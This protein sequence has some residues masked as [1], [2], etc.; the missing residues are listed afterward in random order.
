M[1]VAVDKNGNRA[2]TEA[3]NVLALNPN[4]TTVT[5]YADADGMLRYN[6]EMQN[7]FSVTLPAGSKWDDE[8]VQAIIN[9]IVVLPYESSVD[10]KI[11]M[12]T[13]WK[14]SDGI[15]AIPERGVVISDCS[16]YASY[17]IDTTSFQSGA[18][19]DG[20]VYDGIGAVSDYSIAF[21]N[22]D[23]GAFDYVIIDLGKEYHSLTEF[24]M[25][26]YADGA[27]AL[28]TRITFEVSSKVYVPTMSGDIIFDDWKTVVEYTSNDFIENNGRYLLNGT[29]ANA[30]GRY[31][32]ISFFYDNADSGLLI[33]EIMVIGTENE[34]SAEFDY[35]MLWSDDYL[36][37]ALQYESNEIPF[38]VADNNEGKDASSFRLFMS[39][40]NLNDVARYDY[41]NYD[42]VLDI[43]VNGDGS[44][45]FQS[46]SLGS[47]NTENLTGQASFDGTLMTVELAIPF[48][49]LGF[50]GGNNGN[51]YVQQGIN[52]PL[53]KRTLMQ[54]D[55]GQIFYADPTEFGYLIQ[56]APE[57][58][59]YQDMSY[60]N[61]EGNATISSARNEV[62]NTQNGV[63]IEY[64]PATFDVDGFK[65][66]EAN[67]MY[68]FASKASEENG[69]AS[70]VLTVPN[71]GAYFSFDW[72]MSGADAD[73]LSVS[74]N[75]V[76]IAE[77]HGNGWSFNET[78]TIKVYSPLNTNGYNDVSDWNNVT[79]FIPSSGTY[80]VK[81]LFAKAVESTGEAQITNFRLATED[82]LGY[83]KSSANWD[84]LRLD[85]NTVD[86]SELILGV[87][88]IVDNLGDV[89]S[90]TSHD[91][92]GT[93]SF[94]TLSY[95]AIIDGA[96]ETQDRISISA[97]NIDMA[98]IENYKNNAIVYTNAF[99]G[100]IA[101]ASLLDWTVLQLNY[102]GIA[103]TWELSAIFDE[104]VDKSKF[105][106]K[107][108]DDTLVIL[109]NY[110]NNAEQPTDAVLF[111]YGNR[112]ILAEMTPSIRYSV[113]EDIVVE[114]ASNEN[115]KLSVVN[116]SNKAD[117]NIAEG[118]P[119]TLKHNPNGDY[120]EQNITYVAPE[121][122]TVNGNTYNT[123]LHGD[124]VTV[125][126]GGILT[127]GEFIDV[128]SKAIFSGALEGSV[129]GYS[130]KDTMFSSTAD[131]MVREENI[132]ID[133]GLA[134]TGLSA[135]TA[136]F[137]GGGENGVVFPASV[138]FSVST[139]GINYYYIGTVTRDGV[140]FN[141]TIFTDAFASVICTG[142]TDTIYGNTVADYT[143]N[144]CTVGV[145]A[146]YIKATIMN[147]SAQN[148]NTLISEV[149]VI[150]NFVEYDSL[151]AATL[152]EAFID[153]SDDATLMYRNGVEGDDH[154]YG[155][156]YIFAS[157]IDDEYPDAG[158]ILTD[159]NG[160]ATLYGTTPTLEEIKN[161]SVGWSKSSPAVTFDLKES[162]GIG[163]IVV[164]AMETKGGT[165]VKPGAITAYV[166]NDGAEWTKFATVYAS[167]NGVDTVVETSDYTIY[168]YTLAFARDGELAK[169][170]EGR[171][172][173]KLVVDS[174]EEGTVCITE[175]EMYDGM[176]CYP[177]YDLTEAK[178]KKTALGLTSDEIANQNSEVRPT[179]FRGFYDTK[180]YYSEIQ[181]SGAYNEQA[182]K[183]YSLNMVF[184]SI[185]ESLDYV[186]AN[187][188]QRALS[189]K[190]TPYFY[191]GD[192]LLLRVT[193]D[194]LNSDGYDINGQWISSYKLS[195]ESKIY[196]NNVVSADNTE[197][198]RLYTTTSVPTPM[199][200]CNVLAR[201]KFEAEGSEFEQ[202]PDGIPA[203]VINGYKYYSYLPIYML[204]SLDYLKATGYGVDTTNSGAAR[205]IHM[206]SNKVEITGT[207]VWD[208]NTQGA[209]DEYISDQNGISLNLAP[210][211]AKTNTDEITYNGMTF[212]AESTLRF[213]S[214]WYIDDAA[215]YNTHTHKQQYGTILLTMNNLER[216][217]TDTLSS[218]YTSAY[219]D[220]GIRLTQVSSTEL[221]NISEVT[222][223]QEVIKLTGV[224]EITEVTAN[225][226]YSFTTENGTRYWYSSNSAVKTISFT[227]VVD[228]VTKYWG[229][230][231]NVDRYNWT[232]VDENGVESYWY[233][234]D[235]SHV[236]FEGVKYNILAD[237][238]S[239]VYYINS[240]D[241]SHNNAL[242]RCETD[243]NIVTKNDNTTRFWQTDE[244]GG[245][246]TKMYWSYTT[247]ED[248]VT[249]YWF[250]TDLEGPAGT[251]ITKDGKVY[252]ASEVGGYNDIVTT[253]E[254]T[255]KTR[256][257][258]AKDEYAFKMLVDLKATFE[259]DANGYPV[260]NE[261]SAMK[262]LSILLDYVNNYGEGR[263]NK[264][265]DSLSFGGLASNVRATK[266]Y[267]Y[268][269]ISKYLVPENYGEGD[270]FNQYDKDTSYN[271]TQLLGDY[272]FDQRYVEFDAILA[273]IPSSNKSSKVVAIPYA[274]YANNYEFLEFG[275]TL[276]NGDEYVADTW[277]EV[278]N[279]YYGN[280]NEKHNIRYYVYGEG[281]IRSVDGILNTQ[282]SN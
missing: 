201:D 74:I 118:K 190:G 120:T 57:G 63:A 254:I 114:A 64:T 60:T 229:C 68:Y 216:Y 20:V 155:R 4:P 22:D 200:V 267:Y 263:Y 6:G 46:T 244:I 119:Y 99:V 168:K 51:Y 56:M 79:V 170:L 202:L 104:G 207:V 280:G 249:K 186:Y 208:T 12:F 40:A 95:A 233:T 76:E 154:L 117:Y 172:S 122:I 100:D 26:F 33:D 31:V 131:S 220:Y 282:S 219:I 17:Y 126:A 162:N 192:Q 184:N 125:T 260:S 153:V 107:P 55:N 43:Y 116:V 121:Y 166:S 215:Y 205:F 228:G 279:K 67:G 7:S 108:D 272:N 25:S 250:T 85:S 142:D 212:G 35:K 232:G 271:S 90:T 132:V 10:G 82:E 224:T 93:G 98:D 148:E 66:G 30:N 42:F 103:N 1:I 213:G 91:T 209:S 165:V 16:F 274:V 278:F 138:D 13:Q 3:Q 150:K 2:E 197:S 270:I 171:N 54:L 259:L 137:A 226:T 147:D 19:T 5:F 71:G 252:I 73:K 178:Y 58:K 211:G 8:S 217:L 129:I 157:A 214:I 176:V 231:E 196:F 203:D 105:N 177:V 276:G 152:P 59:G 183:E 106:I 257:W 9:S 237:G 175:V 169:Q 164:Y 61:G 109:I 23:G 265:G 27:K 123:N 65:Y 188:E 139:D 97:A 268:N 136:R 248:S 151:T 111:G 258:T 191:E 48:S 163:Y 243:F 38:I 45:V 80:T 81:W 179:L 255:N 37:I 218:K 127:N 149:A 128:Y 227:T 72:K 266:Y 277:F 161:M 269:N 158:N 77:I 240:N 96:T 47:V 28:P 160:G 101:S 52:K 141:N 62:L 53:G 264:P 253:R 180:T 130:T 182:T 256:Y 159:G 239:V 199:T 195:A 87:K 194:K 223:L 102:T 210:L 41:G 115:T 281:I 94:A 32:K 156:N 187:V 124:T 275:E 134:E 135:F 245:S 222:G 206:P 241:S 83:W 21:G 70:T 246:D 145:T 34:A 24:N 113:V 174:A 181:S 36:Y 78:E 11:Y 262:G 84:T 198:I 143:I 236:S 193:T 230:N 133:L 50:T 221:M 92:F 49:E 167:L 234:A 247:V 146:R 69:S 189:S 140:G 238:A 88:P 89:I 112:Q 15:A 110:T 18:L 75:D 225:D 235:A 39:P 251:V 44:V 185:D 242:T 204:N 144:L 86:S 29:N 14:D 261:E 173:L 273:G